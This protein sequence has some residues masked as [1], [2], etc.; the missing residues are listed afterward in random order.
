MIITLITA[1]FGIVS[2]LLA[3]FLNPKRK[4]YAQIDSIYKELEMLYVKRDEAL[5]A[6]DINAISD[7]AARIVGLRDEKDRILKRQ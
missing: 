7:I 1:V 4:M 5:A 2:T 6:N 3:W